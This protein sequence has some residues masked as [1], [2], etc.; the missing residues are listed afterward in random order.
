MELGTINNTQT[1]LTSLSKK[2]DLDIPTPAATAQ[3]KSN[4]EKLISPSTV[5]SLSDEGLSIP[6]DVIPPTIEKSD[7]E[8]EAMSYDQ[9]IEERDGKLIHSG[10]LSLRFV[11]ETGK[12]SQY[13]AIKLADQ[14]SANSSSA[15]S[16]RKNLDDFKS[17]AIKEI[18]GLASNDFDVSF[19]DNKVIIVS[20]TLSNDKK[21]KLQASLD[22]DSK[23]STS[24][25]DSINTF[26][27]VGLT[28]INMRLTSEKARF[29]GPENIYAHR[30][31]PLTMEEFTD[32]IS[33]SGVAASE[34]GSTYNKYSSIVGSTTFGNVY[35]EK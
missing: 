6:Q 9:L 13:A 24:L 4:V 29:D 28:L 23:F 25:K 31:S 3:I 1:I 16:V 10:D 20:S 15:I 27:D 12:A 11:K 8:Y 18:G 5:V 26:N 30:D 35:I 14:M 2:A 32:S 34:G 21:I 17:N 22:S 7:A 33:Y 19:N